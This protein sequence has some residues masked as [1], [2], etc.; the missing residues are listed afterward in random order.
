MALAML[1][2]GL[3]EAVRAAPTADKPSPIVPPLLG[4]RADFSDGKLSGWRHKE[5]AQIEIVADGVK[6]VLHLSSRF[7]PFDFTWAT[8]SFAPHTTAGLAHVRFRIAGDGSGHRLQVHLGGQGSGDKRPHYYVNNTQSPKLDFTGWRTVTLDLEHFETPA[9]ALRKPDLAAVVFLEFMVVVER[10]TDGTAAGKSTNV[11]LRLADVEFIGLTPEE[12]TALRQQT[13]RRQQLCQAAQPRLVEVE[14]QLAG[15]RTNIDSL[16]GQGKYVDVARVYLAALTWCVADVR[17]GLEA[18]ELAIVAQADT[19]LADLARRAGQT[20]RVIGHVRDRGNQEPDTLD[21]EHNPYFKGCADVVRAQSRA[22]RTWAKGRKGYEAISNAWDFRTLGDSVYETLWVATRPHSPLRHH[23]RAITNALSLFDTIAHQHTAG[24][25]NIDRT[26]VF[27]RDPNINRFCLAPTLD[28]WLLLKAAYPELLP[29]AKQAEIEAG[30]KVLADYQVTEY[31]T[32]R[33]AKEPYVKFPT[34]LNMDVHHILIMEFARRLWGQSPYAAERDAFLQGVLRAVYPDGAWPYINSQNECFIYHLVDVDLLARY[35]KLSG[36]PAVLAV[37][38]KT[39]PFYPDNVEPAGMPEYYTDPCWKHYWGGGAPHGPEIIAGLFDDPPNKRVAETAAAVWGYG[40]GYHS[41]IVAEFFKPLASQPQADGYLH[42]DHNIEGPRGRYGT[43]S[44]A[45]NGRNYQVGYQGKD[46]FIG[47]MLTDPAARPLPLDSALQVVTTEVRLKHD[48]NHWSGARSFSA[49]EK[50][51]T[52]VGPDFGS[53]A[54]RYTL[55]TPNWHHK[56]DE[57]LPW[58]GTQE[59]YLSKTRLVGLVALEAM[60]D[61][62]QAAVQGRI[63]LG[64]SRPIE[65]VGK[66]PDEHAWHYGRLR[67]KIHAHNYA[68][69]V[70]R[71]SETF[72]QDKP[73]KYRSTEI[74]LVDPLSVKAGGKGLVKYPRGTRYWFLVEI[75]PDSSPPAEE[76]LPIGNPEA[77]SDGIVGFALLDADRRVAVLHNPTDQPLVMAVPMAK[78]TEQVE[79]YRRHDGRGEA[80]GKGAARITLGPH[81][82]AVIVGK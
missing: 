43:W 26:A 78:T 54:V 64:L 46:T 38:R 58:D 80:I 55:S 75:F 29:P 11:D 10:K 25:F 62:T 53:L 22:D 42:F 68:Q 39:V 57:L 3:T 31:G 32:V 36:D 12:E 69:I 73:D 21:V 33:L 52:T 45:G 82:H 7:D 81:Q 15:L 51:T 48:Q 14:S 16:A 66:T 35:W 27:G 17:R 79:V 71:P 44:F 50:L 23:P 30:L 19:L 8:W 34:Y 47:A 37:L 40:H 72:F 61:E 63:R 1:C 24:D 76:V 9:N 6:K 60:A 20:S 70:I 41:A 49:L 65:A 28:A 74:T 67:I 77:T 4:L 13:A 5:N 56:N 2:V 18:D 59:W